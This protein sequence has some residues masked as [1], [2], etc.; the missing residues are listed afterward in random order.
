M[1]ASKE[2]RQQQQEERKLAGDTVQ[3]PLETSP[4]VQYK[5]DDGLEDYKLRAYGARGHLPVSDVPHGGTG[6][7]APT[8]PGTAVPTGKRQPQRDQG[9]AVAG[10][11]V[12]T[13]TDAIN[14][15]G[16]P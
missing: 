15:H 2:R 8:V 13:A 12:G 6:T 5:K 1:E 16:V 4:Y 10:G 9:G 3:L 11:D 7:D 14:R